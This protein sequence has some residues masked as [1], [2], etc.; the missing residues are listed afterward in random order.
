LNDF[1]T[2]CFLIEVWRMMNE[3]ETSFFI[4]SPNFATV[5]IKNLKI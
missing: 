4:I 3:K 1:W 5:T 2:L